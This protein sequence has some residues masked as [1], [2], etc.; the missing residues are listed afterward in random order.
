VYPSEY[1]YHDNSVT[2]A[3]SVSANC[4]S[5][6]PRDGDTGF[7][8]THCDGKQLKLSDSDR[9]SNTEYTATSYYVWT[10]ESAEQL[11]FIFPTIVSL[12]TITLHYYSDS[13]RGLPR[14]RLYAVSDDFNVWDATTTGIPYLGIP[15]APSGREPASHRNI[16]LNF[17]TK[18]VLMYKFSSSLAFAV[19]EVEFFT[20][21][22]KH[23]LPIVIQFKVLCL[24]VMNQL[25]I[26]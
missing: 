8:Y 22:C 16:R 14:L 5:Y 25:L 6:P 17:N 11:L 9:G 18:K 15:A 4:R 19:S 7:V 26:L 24:Q 12:T 20:M 3:E 21:S 10:A 13:L 2:R 1:A 23:R